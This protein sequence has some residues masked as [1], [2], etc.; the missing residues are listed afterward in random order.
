MD[1]TT[2]KRIKLRNLFLDNTFLRGKNQIRKDLEVLSGGLS[3]EDFL[4]FS[5]L[6]HVEG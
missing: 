5:A 3:T 2:F 1:D 4:V 6:G